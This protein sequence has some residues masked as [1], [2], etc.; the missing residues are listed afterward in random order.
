MRLLDRLISRQ[1]GY[2]EGMASGAAILTQT[3]GDPNK[4]KIMPTVSAWA[5]QVNGSSAV[6][7]AAI[8]ARMMLFSEASFA[9][10]ANDDKHLYTTSALAPLQDPWPGGTEGELLA[11]MEQD[12]SVA[13]N[14]FIW[15]PPGGKRLVRLRPDWTTIV[16]EIVT[17]PGGGSYRNVIGYHVLPPRSVLDQQPGEFYPADEVAHYAPIPD[18][19]ANFRGMSWLTPVYRDVNADSGLIDYKIKYLENSASPN[20]LIRYAQKLQPGTIDSV[21]ERIHARYGGVANAFKTLVLDQGADVTIIGNSL[22]QMDFTNVQQAGAERILAA[23]GVPTLVVGL[24]SMQGSGVRSYPDVM[25]RFANLTMWPLWRSACSAL[26]TLIDIPSGV[27]LAVDTGSIPALQDAEQVRAQVSLVRAQALMAYT[28]AGFTRDSAV[29]AVD[30]GDINQL[31]AEPLAAA[32]AA[33]NVQHLLP[34]TPPGATA[35]PLPPMMPRLPVGSTSPGDGGNHTRPTPR[36]V[37]ARRQHAI[38][39]GHSPG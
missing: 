34:Q 6:V 2:W 30:S 11:R 39:N 15:A 28:Q 32:P 33:G 7:F 24:E 17:V 19:D 38:T 5:H 22:E 37:S 13:G 3:Y 27:T 35:D 18:P 29:A 4:E 16:S 36:P 10:Q 9:L 12:A 20:V 26:E 14:C 31:E 23:A 1:G 21:R 8:C 25:H